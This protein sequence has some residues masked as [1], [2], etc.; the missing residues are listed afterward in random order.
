M[1]PQ[2]PITQA[3]LRI[4]YPDLNEKGATKVSKQESDMMKITFL[5]NVFQ[6]LISKID[7]KHSNPEA[8][9]Q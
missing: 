8:G 6:T 4:F 3:T 1:K 2:E 7:W 5:P 9:G